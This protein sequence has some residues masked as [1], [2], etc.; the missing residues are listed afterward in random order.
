M[1]SRRPIKDSGGEKAPP[2]D[3]LK[4][5]DTEQDAAPRR[6][7]K[8]SRVAGRS[9]WQRFK[10]WF[11]DFRLYMYVL[12]FAGSFVLFFLGV[13]SIWAQRLLGPGLESWFKALGSYNSYLFF[14]GLVCII[15]SAYVFFALLSKLAEFRRLV[16]TK[17]K[18][19]FVHGLDRI[20]RLAFELG[21][22]ANEVVADRKREFRIRH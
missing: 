14:A 20:E 12:F 10:S 22:Q 6:A 13:L 16:S 9:K 19:D 15:T 4:D 3:D 1:P 17:S 2:Q 18:G 11:R 8:A 21:T 7:P 5:A